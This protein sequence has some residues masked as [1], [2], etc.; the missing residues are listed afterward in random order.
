[1]E[2][3]VE[4][5]GAA[6]GSP[7]STSADEGPAYQKRLEISLIGELSVRQGGETLALPR[8]RKCRALIAYLAATARPQRREHLCE[9]LWE[10]PDDPRGSLR[11][12]LSK[13]RRVL[14]DALIADGELVSIDR[15][16]ATIDAAELL[17]VAEPLDTIANEELERLAGRCDQAFGQDLDLPRCQEFEG[18]LIAVREDV[19]LA[20]LALLAELVRR[21]RDDP[22]RA[23]PFAR[24]RVACDP[25]DERA[26][27]D[28]LE[29]LA[30]A[31]R[32]D[33]AERQRRLAVDVLKDAGIAV[34]TAL[35]RPFRKPEAAVPPA[36]PQIQ[37][38]Q[39]CTAPDGTRIAY[40]RVGSGPPIVKTAN[41]MSH[42]EYEW[43][44]P[45]LRHWL[46]EL[47]REHSLVRY[48]ARG[49]GLSDHGAADLS[50]DAFV[51]DLETVTASLAGER[52]DLVGLSQG[53]AVAIAFAARHPE[54]VRKLILYGGF[55]S[56]WRHHPSEEVQKQRQAMITLTE[57][58]WGLNNPAFRQL[59]TSLF[60]PKAPPEAAD[61]FNELQRVSASPREAQ[62]LQLAVAEF[63]VRDQLAAVKAPTI[64]FHCRDD[65][66]VSLANGRRLAAG[67]PGAEFVGLDS[68]NHLLLE[69]E[70]AWPVFV[71]HLRDFL[72]R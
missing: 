56:G 9:L 69:D 44:S 50:L 21:L 68:E 47:S 12:S 72:A 41:W 60:F 23:L 1:M 71:A 18:W 31:G 62:R 6:G 14:G 40:S 64:V 48:D 58:G 13:I 55:P 66:M 42:L 46:V 70:P 37:R 53:C 3:G 22:D 51:Q 36:R 35:S 8:S 25:L 39:F 43:Q 26:R 38:I 61:W 54:R 34:P 57:F 10:V 2:T 20:Q 52:F 7:I 29:V 11:W 32:T 24:A 63:D 27:L 65:A 16:A 19:R 17:G 28:L 5:A 4:N 67:I 33:E 59:F 15:Q 45:I 49:N 30:A